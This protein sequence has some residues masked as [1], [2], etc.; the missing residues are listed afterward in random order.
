MQT[1]DIS[2]VIPTRNERE[3][4][5]PLIARLSAALPAGAEVIFVDDSTDDT[6]EVIAEVAETATLPVL[7]MHRGPG[8]R[9]GGLGGAVVAGL[10][11]AVG[12]VVVVMDGDLQHPPD[13]IPDA[14][15][16]HR[17]GDADIVVASRYRENGGRTVWPPDP[18]LACPGWPRA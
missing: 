4:I 2:V 3:N 5:A 10:R 18:G 8:E 7:T 17:A 13:S 12:R 16:A 6:P 15:P 11:L 14:D 1:I 9:I